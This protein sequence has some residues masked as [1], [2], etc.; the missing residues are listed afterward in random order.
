SRFLKFLDD[1]AKN[2]PEIFKEFWN[3][4]SIFLKE[5]A[6]ND[7]TH[8]QEILKLLRFE[9]SKT[10][11]GELISLGDYV[12]RMKEGQEAIYFINGPTRQI[13]EEGPYLE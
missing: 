4:F 8:R 10:G 7:F 11:E 2:E 12:G 9:S 3:E 5:G 13:I 6:A 1:Q